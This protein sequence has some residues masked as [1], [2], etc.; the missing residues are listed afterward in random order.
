LTVDQASEIKR[1][2]SD[3]RAVHAARFAIE[4]AADAAYAV[5]CAAIAAIGA[6]NAARAAYYAV[7]AA[8]REV[9]YAVDVATYATSYAADYAADYATYAATYDDRD[10]IDDASKHNQQALNIK[11]LKQVIN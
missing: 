2:I 9:R 11:F 8:A 7:F 4:A 3:A 5:R 6:T 10:S 1:H